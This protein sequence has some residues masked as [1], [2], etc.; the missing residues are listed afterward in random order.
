MTSLDRY[1]SQNGIQRVDLVR[2]DAEGSELEVLDGATEM[3]KRIRPIFICEVVDETTAAWGYPAREI[4]S[5]LSQAGYDWFECDA[6][7]GLIPHE[8]RE[9]YP[10]A[11]NYVAVPE[12]KLSLVQLRSDSA[13]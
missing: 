11:K 5:R 1:I 2:L 6:D 8:I 4:V 3:F 13:R 10:A 9:G 7:G 12:E